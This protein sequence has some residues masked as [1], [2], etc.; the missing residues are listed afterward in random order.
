MT[1]TN[2]GVAGE[3][4]AAMR[5][6]RHAILDETIAFRPLLQQCSH[7]LRRERASVRGMDSLGL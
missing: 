2:D 1:N 5:L 6:P 4:P 3:Q 7:S